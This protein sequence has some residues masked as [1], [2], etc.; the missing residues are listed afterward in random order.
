[1]SERLSEEGREGGG[2]ER[3]REGKETWGTRWTERA[4]GGM[5]GSRGHGRR[6]RARKET[7]GGKERE[8]GGEDRGHERRPR[9]REEARGRER[10]QRGR[11]GRK[12][13]ERGGG[14][15]RLT[16]GSEATLERSPIDT[17]GGVP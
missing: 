14:S 12:Q 6:Q 11:A 4:R 1:M 5:R 16:A 9:A 10:I 13:R 2:N 17:V 7:A 15:R 8:G 3:E